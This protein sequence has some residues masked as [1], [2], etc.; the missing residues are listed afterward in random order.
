MD[1]RRGDWGDIYARL[2]ALDT[3]PPTALFTRDPTVGRVG[4]AFTLNAWPS[5]DDLTP[6]GALA[7][8]WDW[9][10]DGTWDT[11]WDLD[12]SVTITPAAQGVYT[13]TLQ[14]H[15][16]MWLADTISLPIYVLPVS[17]NTPPQAYLTVLPLWA[18]AGAEFELNATGCSDA[19]TPYADLEVRWDWENDGVWNTQF[20]KNDKVITH[21]YTEAGPYV[22]RVEVRDGGSLTDAAVDSFLLLPATP[23]LL[24]VDP[25]VTKTWPGL[26]T[27]FTATAWDQYGNEM[28]NPPVTWSLADPQAGTIDAD[29]LFTAGIVA[30]LYN[31][32]VVATW[33]QLSGAAQVLIYYP[34]ECHL[35]VVM[36]NYP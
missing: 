18:Q 34:Y 28:H 13:V 1:G 15:D 8:R 9:T 4:D 26:T 35:P 10:S 24:E 5:H 31:E 19:E 29:G 6:S 27:R 22:V 17:A 14:V 11:A 12:K 25:P 7:V 23:T 20:S 2:G 36:K 33:G 16:L 21:I 30:G 32:V 3:T